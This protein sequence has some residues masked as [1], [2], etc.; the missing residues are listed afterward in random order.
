[1]KNDFNKKDC[2]V[3]RAGGERR[4]PRSVVS[5]QIVCIDFLPEVV[6]QI[7]QRNH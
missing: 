3:P 2:L 7:A 6:R 4:A 5:S 1:M